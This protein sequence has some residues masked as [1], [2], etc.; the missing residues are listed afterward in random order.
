MGSALD[1]GLNASI[2]LTDLSKAFNSISYELLI[3]NDD[4]DDDDD[5]M[6]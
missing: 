6:V 4:D 2:L 5:E 1:K 3:A